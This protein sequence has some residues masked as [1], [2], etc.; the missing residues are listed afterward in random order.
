[1]IRGYGIRDPAQSYWTTWGKLHQ[2]PGQSV[3]EYNVAFEQAMTDLGP[4]LTDEQ[5]K[6]EKYKE[7]LHANLREVCRT[8]AAGQRWATLQELMDFATNKWPT[9]ESQIAKAKASAPTRTVGGKRKATGGSPGKRAKLG[10]VLSAEQ[11]KHNMDNHLCHKC[12]KPG[13]I[14]INCTEGSSSGN[15]SK[16]KGKANSNKSKEKSGVDF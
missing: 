1:M 9:V 10:V 5:V 14:A 12:G 7:G 16:K 13:H 2:G 11:L 8:N 6:I 3:D 4:Q 15:A